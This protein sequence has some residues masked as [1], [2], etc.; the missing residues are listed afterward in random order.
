MKTRHFAS[1]LLVV[2]VCGCGE[3]V[4]TSADLDAGNDELADAAGAVD[5]GDHADAALAAPNIR[6]AALCAEPA[7]DYHPWHINEASND[8]DL[9]LLIKTV[10][11]SD[12]PSAVCNDGTPAVYYVRAGSG[13]GANRWM[14]HLQGGGGCGNPDECYERWCSIGTSYDQS[15][16]STAWAPPAMAGTGLF[17][18]SDANA[19]AAW[20]HVFVYYCSSDAWSGQAADTMLEPAAYPAYTAHFEGHDIVAA[21]VAELKAGATSD[22]G[23]RAMPSIDDAQAVLLQG[24]SAGSGGVRDNVDWVGAELRATNP[25]V[26]YRGIADAAITPDSADYLPPTDY[27]IVMA[28]R[29]AWGTE[30]RHS[31]LDESCAAY[32][33]PTGDARVCENYVHVL[34]HHISTPMFVRMDLR[35]SNPLP[36]LNPVT[37][38]PLGN[39]TDFAIA[40]AAQLDS[41]A[42]LGTATSEAEEQGAATGAP[43][44]FGPQCGAHSGILTTNVFSHRL[45][46]GDAWY[47]AHDLLVNWLL[48]L[49]PSQLI[50][51]P[52]APSTACGN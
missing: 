19:F 31:F 26:A 49:A 10:D 36:W 47:N 39:T 30:A 32:H 27:D 14:I 6:A 16:M 41:L 7:D 33:Q 2:T 37:A 11:G 50:D 35:D 48:G 28:V 44:I 13:M 3:P 42:R 15:K 4:T 23:T 43:G 20:N 17:S 18:A 8:P 51:D 9:N 12:H 25:D 1:V 38:A 52:L 40:V 34:R 29:E 45:T 46:D 24:T 21:V 5:A 22:D